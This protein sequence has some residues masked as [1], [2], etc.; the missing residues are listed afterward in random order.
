MQSLCEC[1]FS[2]F[3]FKHFGSHLIE[4]WECHDFLF[5]N[6]INYTS[7]IRFFKSKFSW[8]WQQME[9]ELLCWFFHKTAIRDLFSSIFHI[10]CYFLSKCLMIWFTKV[11]NMVTI[12]IVCKYKK[13]CDLSFSAYAPCKMVKIRILFILNH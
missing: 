10:T 6:L 7:A 2:I 3:R 4:T 1:E 8:K 12:V 11:T 13:D 5:R 9:T